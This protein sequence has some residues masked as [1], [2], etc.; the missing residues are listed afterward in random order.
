MMSDNKKIIGPSNILFFP[1]E[2]LCSDSDIDLKSKSGV[3]SRSLPKLISTKF[4]ALNKL[5]IFY[6]YFLAKNKE[7]KNV[8]NDS[9]KS[10]DVSFLEEYVQKSNIQAD[11]VIS[12]TIKLVPDYSP[13]VPN[14]NLNA[15]NIELFMYNPDDKSKIDINSYSFA[16]KDMPLIIPKMLK[17]ICSC[18]D[19]ENAIFTDE[20]KNKLMIC[21]TT[22]FN[23][24]KNYFYTIEILASRNPYEKLGDS[25]LTYLYDS[26]KSDP[27]FVFTIE[28][29]AFICDDFLRFGEKQEALK[30]CEKLINISGHFKFYLTL[31]KIQL[32]LNNYD[33]TFEALKNGISRNPDIGDVAYNMGQLAISL[34]RIEEAKYAFKAM[35]DSDYML[36]I[37]YD[38]LGVIHAS[39]GEIEQA[40]DCWHRSIEFDPAKVS[41]YAN[42]G[43]A[44]LEKGEMRKSEDYLKKAE[45][46]NSS[47][48]MTYLN[49]SELYKKNGNLKK[50]E[51]CYKKAVYYNPDLNFSDE[52][53]KALR[54]ANELTD[55]NR[56]FEAIKMYDKVISENER[57]WQAHF[58]K[59]IAC[60]KLKKLAEAEESFMKACEINRN[61][62]DSQNELGLI[63]LLKSNFNDA[64]MLFNRALEISPE[65]SGYICN[66]GLCY[67]EM[68]KYESARHYLYKAKYLNPQ[69]TKIDECIELLNKVI[70]DEKQKKD[71]QNEAG[72][73]ENR[74]KK[75][76]PGNGETPGFIDRIKNI[77]KK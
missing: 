25:V 48:F 72:Q 23:C 57:C 42:L 46:I 19:P 10:S 45:K 11:C 34:N 21:D 6:I 49:M 67:L 47:Y 61:F 26:L 63:Y 38:N 50:A 14:K 71:N 41:A 16:E 30:I 35:I 40:I 17:D 68:K 20:E 52:Q 74:P 2:C 59:G 31:G 55:N 76:Q 75:P 58:F 62:P 36:P 37:A 27:E 73:T 8:L 28:I 33:A 66:L 4:E 29:G 65:N 22:N 13:A 54:D 18:V 12:G 64:I 24:L 3:Y 9:Q 77:F 15:V 51:E 44:Y 70:N 60:R 56:E 1:L 69:D 7:N 5:K 39:A 43:R 53:R 32:Q